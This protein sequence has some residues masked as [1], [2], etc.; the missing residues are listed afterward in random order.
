MWMKPYPLLKS[1]SISS[2]APPDNTY[3]I[4]AYV[5]DMHAYAS[6]YDITS[7]KAV[8]GCSSSLLILWVEISS[9]LAAKAMFS[10]PYLLIPLFSRS[11]SLTLFFSL[12]LHVLQCLSPAQIEI[13]HL[14]TAARVKSAD[15]LSGGL[16]S[17]CYLVMQLR[18]NHLMCTNTPTRTQTHTNRC[19]LLCYRQSPWCY[20]SVKH[21][22]AQILRSVCLEARAHL[23][24]PA[25]SSRQR[26]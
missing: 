10:F 5:S 17:F 21:I 6:T 13:D 24:A 15:W 20:P 7:I 2:V 14:C 8:C 16:I 11:F 22:S 18:L 3:V 12:S 26:C 4:Y 9:A 19:T 25:H 1:C 23:S